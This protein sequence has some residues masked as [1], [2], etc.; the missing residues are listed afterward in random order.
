MLLILYVLGF[1]GIVVAVGRAHVDRHQGRFLDYRALA[2]ALRVVMYW[3]ILG[4]ASPNGGAP[5][6]LPPGVH[7]PGTIADAYP[8]KQPSELAWVK[9]PLRV[10]ALVESGDAS[11]VQGRLDTAG[12][13]VARHGWVGNTPIP[14]RGYRLKRHAD[15]IS[16][17]GLPGRIGAIRDRAD[18]AGAMA[19]ADR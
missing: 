15:M 19:G 11:S 8:I 5:E 1:L 4:I 13:A 18:C 6:P 16:A 2:E 14:T 12:H 3:R 17:H 9:V 10:L 7:N